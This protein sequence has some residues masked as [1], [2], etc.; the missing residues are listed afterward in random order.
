MPDQ[1]LLLGIDLG[2]TTF[3]VGVLGPEPRLIRVA[4]RPTPTGRSPADLLEG[5]VKAL[6]ALLDEAGIDRKAIAGAGIAI[7]G[8]VDAVRGRSRFAPNLPGWRDVPVRDLLEEALGLPVVLDHDVR[9]ATLAE[10]RLG[11]GRGTRTFACVTVG[12]GIGAGLV[13]DG[14]LYRGAG[15]GAGEI[16]HLPVAA[17]D[18]PCGCGR[19]GCLETVASGRAIGER[20]RALVRAGERTSALELAGRDVDRITAREVLAAAASGDPLAGRVAGEALEA[21]VLGLVAL[22]NVIDPEVIAIGGGVAQAGPWLFDR[23]RGLVRAR[24]WPP[25]AETVRLEPAALGPRAGV[26]G[27]GVLAAETFGGDSRRPW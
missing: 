10:Y 19:H 27:A 9:M 16:G 7:P 6:F 12:T 25:G 11:V 26:I 5:V 24:A 8:S 1:H 22:V 21:L 13:L 4:E 20:V 18:S 23:L 2:G 14:A 3:R 15:G 17:N